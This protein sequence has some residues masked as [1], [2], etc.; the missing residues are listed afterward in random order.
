MPEPPVLTTERLRLRPFALS[1]GADVQRLAGAR[2]VA[3]TTLNI[4]HPYEDGMA[5]K[6]IGGHRA[7]FEDGVEAIFAITRKADGALVG[8]ISLMHI[9]RVH[10][11]AEM[12][13]WIGVP[14]WNQGYATEA[15][16]AVLSYAF[17]ELGLH[18]VWAQHMTRNPASGRVLRKIGMQH[19]GRLRQHV[20]KNGAFEDLESY[21]I[22]SGEAAAPSS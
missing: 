13:Y 7:A 17:G 3:D 1:D 14:F 5:E 21:A 10:S 4:P 15:A 16:A 6:W 9:D 19:E 8:A 18:R 11:H 2:E 20:N 22:L 12:G